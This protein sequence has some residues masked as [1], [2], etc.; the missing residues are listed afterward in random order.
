MYI[1]RIKELR[2]DRDISQKEIA[3]YLKIPKN[4]YS[5]YEN[6]KRHFP[7]EYIIEIAKYFNVSLDYLFNLTDTMK[8]YPRK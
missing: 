7:L 4:T 6:D 1:E 5:Q 2:T 8:V 3:L